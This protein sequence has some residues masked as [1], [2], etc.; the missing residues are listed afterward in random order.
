MKKLTQSEFEERIHDL[1]PDIKV[2][3]NYINK[4]TRIIVSCKNCGNIWEPIADS[5]LSGHGCS[6]CARDGKAG[7]RKPIIIKGV[8]DLFTSM[9]NY[10]KHLKDK[11][12]AF[13]YT[14]GSSKKILWICPSCHMDIE[15]KISQV[16]SQGILCPFCGDGFSYPNKFM[17]NF[18]KQLNIKFTRE[19]RIDNYYYDVLIDGT[20]II[21]EMDGG[22]HFIDNNMTGES[23]EDICKRDVLKSNVAKNNGY[24]LIRIDAQKS[25]VNYLKEQISSS[26]II[27][28]LNISNKLQEVDWESIAKLS[29]KSLFFDVIDLYN[30]G[31]T[32]CEDIIIHL[33]ISIHNSTVYAYLKRGN[34]LGLCSYIPKTNKRKIRC[35]QENIYFNSIKQAQDY[36]GFSSNAGI[37]NSCKK[38]TSCYISKDNKR[39]RINFEYVD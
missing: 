29:E 25:D 23:K 16:Y 32:S 14:C 24:N 33:P 27:S 31:I 18:L 6:V 9:P 11:E 15:K 8:N 13:K 7:K 5:L 39:I 37:C 26:E 1:L 28:L 3:G 30:Q 10:A 22:F 38:G 20:N 12:D 2:L 21:I 35:I 19:F 34:E 17:Y 36:Y 4:R